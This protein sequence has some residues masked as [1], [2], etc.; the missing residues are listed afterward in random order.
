MRPSHRTTPALFAL[1]LLAGCGGGNEE[2]STNESK[3][4]QADADADA[5]AGADA[6]AK[7]EADAAKV[8]NDEEKGTAELTLGD[9]GEVWKAKRASARL[10]EDGKLRITASVQSISE[11]KTSRRQLT[12][13]IQDYE[14][15]GK[16]AITDMMSNLTAVSLNLGATKKAEAEG[17]E[18]KADEAAT[19]AAIE[20]IQG[21]S[22]LLLKDAKVEITKADENFIDGTI[23]WSGISTS[24]TSKLSGRFHAR[25]KN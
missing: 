21:G 22:V 11:E 10:K 8:P 25:V 12:L 1:A 20:G 24:G 6:D 19:K 5:K 2:A 17:D 13:N 18:A 3:A 4:G 7:D 9:D 15:P 14:G 16:Y 23:E